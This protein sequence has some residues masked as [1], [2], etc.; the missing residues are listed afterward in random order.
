MRSRRSSR[1]PVRPSTSTGG[2]PTAT[3]SALAASATAAAAAAAPADAGQRRARTGTRV[4]PRVRAASAQELERRANVGGDPRL[5]A[6]DRCAADPLRL[7]AGARPGQPQGCCALPGRVR[8]VA[9]CQQ[10]ARRFGSLRAAVEA[11]RRHRRAQE[12]T[13]SRPRWRGANQRQAGGRLPPAAADAVGLRPGG[14]RR[15]GGPATTDALVGCRA[16]VLAWTHA[17]TAGSTAVAASSIC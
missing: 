14:R 12:A 17:W 15:L 10:L 8:Q 5:D 6:A 3:R 1:S 7:V 13:L 16:Q 2:T 4:V 9:Q 11:A